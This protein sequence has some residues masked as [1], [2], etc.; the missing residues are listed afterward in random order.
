MKNEIANWNELPDIMSKEQFYRICH[1]SKTTA[2]QLLRSGRVPCQYSGKKTRCYQIQKEDV[3]KYLEERA[4]FP[5]RYMAPIG[6][7]GKGHTRTAKVALP[8]VC[9]DMT[10]YYISRLD[11]Y[12][13]VLTVRQI[14]DFTGYCKTA[15]NHW[16]LWGWLKHFR[17]GRANI[18]PKVFFVEFLNAE[19]FRAIRRMTAQHIKLLKDFQA[20]KNRSD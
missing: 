19:H 6:W 5:E 14:A 10:E 17:R 7:Y 11:A 16:C 18:V 8:L 9:E 20:W 13:D 4:V 15:I 2:L 12:P 1:I 3:K